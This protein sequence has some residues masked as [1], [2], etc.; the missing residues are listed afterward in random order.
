MGAK[1]K[2]QDDE[3]MLFSQNTLPAIKITESH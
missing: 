1:G 3:A 2:N